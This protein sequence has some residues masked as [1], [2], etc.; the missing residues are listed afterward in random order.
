MELREVTARL[1]RVTAPANRAEGD[2]TFAED[3]GA[4]D[5]FLA[6]H[7]DQLD[8]HLVHYLERRSYTKALAFLEG[9]PGHH[10]AGHNRCPQ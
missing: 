8:R 5:A 6:A 9:D 1:R 7:R 4:L 10:Q 3:L 2:P